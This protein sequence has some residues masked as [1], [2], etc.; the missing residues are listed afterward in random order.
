M[1]EL[2]LEVKKLEPRETKQESCTSC[3]ACCEP[4]NLQG[5]LEWCAACPE[6]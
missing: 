1:K 4:E 3:T 5:L 2:K 6:C